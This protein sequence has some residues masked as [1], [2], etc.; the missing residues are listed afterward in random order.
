VVKGR[1]SVRKILA[2]RMEMMMGGDEDF[3][4][5]DC[6]PSISSVHALFIG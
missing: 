2:W 5:I 4:E 3:H 1:Q 6:F